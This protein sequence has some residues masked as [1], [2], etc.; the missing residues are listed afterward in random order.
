MANPFSDQSL[1]DDQ[2]SLSA[3]EFVCPQCQKTPDATAEMGS[4]ITLQPCGHVFR[5]SDLTTVIEH[6]C[7]LDELIQRHEVATTPFERQGIREEIRAIGAE[8]DTATER[9]TARMEA[10]E[11]I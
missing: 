7:A 10:I 8:L 1:S 3:V 5:R 4:T 11:T 2:F 6:L 9:C